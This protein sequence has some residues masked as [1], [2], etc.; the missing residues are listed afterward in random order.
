MSIRF[1]DDFVKTIALIIL[2]PPAVE[3]AQPPISIKKR[4]I[5]WENAGQEL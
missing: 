5:I 4:I 1:N 3:P 2:S